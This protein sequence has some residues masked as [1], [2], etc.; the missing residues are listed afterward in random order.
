M[1]HPL[2]PTSTLRLPLPA[3][4]ERPCDRRAVLLAGL[5]ACAL[6]TPAATFAADPAGRVSAA[7][8]RSTALQEGALRELAEGSEVFLLD[9]VETRAEARLSLRLGSRTT[10]RLGERTRLKIEKS[11]VEHGGELVLERGALLFDRPDAAQREDA[12]VRTPLAIIAARGTSFWVGPSQD[13]TGVFV[14]RGSVV[15]T[16]GAPRIEAALATVA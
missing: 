2:I 9:L 6:L 8:G 5:A 7:R 1:F 11:V 13:V 4:S 3:L 12:V 16:W 10:L 15:V 14:D